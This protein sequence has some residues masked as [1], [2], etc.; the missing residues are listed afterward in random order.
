MS[1]EK[2][3]VLAPMPRARVRITIQVKPGRWV[4]PPGSQSD[5][6]PDPVHHVLHSYSTSPGAGECRHLGPSLLYVP[7]PPKHASPGFPLGNPLIHQPLDLFL[8]VEG[9]F[10]IDVDSGLTL[11]EEPTPDVTPIGWLFHR[12]DHAAEMPRIWKTARA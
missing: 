9:D 8:D 5:L 3:A 7:E 11:G 4:N 2:T 1:T 6:P 12:P 10:V